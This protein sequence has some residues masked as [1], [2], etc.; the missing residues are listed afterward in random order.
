MLHFYT[1]AFDIHSGAKNMTLYHAIKGNG[2]LTVT[3][4]TQTWP[5]TGRSTSTQTSCPKRDE[6]VIVLKRN[7]G[8][9]NMTSAD[10]ASFYHYDGESVDQFLIQLR[11][12]KETRMKH[13]SVKPSLFLV[14]SAT[15]DH[16]SG[17]VG[18]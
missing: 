13:R 16:T 7:Y 1:I 14:R 5:D 6:P 2:K 15:S 3:T 9:S 18:H 11:K 10:E 17:H 12:H 4:G 8:T